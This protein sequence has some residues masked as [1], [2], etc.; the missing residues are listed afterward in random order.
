MQLDATLIIYALSTLAGVGYAWHAHQ[1]HL[2]MIA[3]KMSAGQ[4]LF[5]G[6]FMMIT[7]F[8]ILLGIGWLAV[9]YGCA[10]PVPLG[11]SFVVGYTIMMA[12]YLRK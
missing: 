10:H 9:Q 4:I 5:H 12:R 6:V 2:R 11:I 1:H 7:R 8:F 3:G